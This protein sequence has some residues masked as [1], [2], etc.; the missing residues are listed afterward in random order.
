MSIPA[1]TA[2]SDP[3]DLPEVARVQSATKHGVFLVGSPMSPASTEVA[4]DRGWIGHDRVRVVD[5]LE[6]PGGLLHVLQ[7]PIWLRPGLRVPVWIDRHRRDRLARTLG[8]VAIAKALV[9]RAGARV[10]S[11]EVV[12]GKAWIELDRETPQPDIAAAMALDPSM[13]ILTADRQRALVVVLGA[14]VTVPAGPIETRLAVIG[15]VQVEAVAPL[16]GGAAAIELSLARGG[17][18]WWH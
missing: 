8:A 17:D 15:D 13:E 1:A 18:A 2:M 9:E 16:G 3:S 11:L 6:E 14:V 4:A 5:V 12:A 7:R 10:V